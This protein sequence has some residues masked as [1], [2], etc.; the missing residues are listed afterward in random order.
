MEDCSYKINNL[1][2]FR[3]HKMMFWNDRYFMILKQAVQ[4]RL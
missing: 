1:D 3:M 2:N 4:K